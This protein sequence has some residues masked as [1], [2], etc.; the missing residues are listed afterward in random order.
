MKT[1]IV[2]VSTGMVGCQ[3]QDSFE[4]EDDTTEEEVEDM[5]REVMFN[6]INWT[7]YT[8]EEK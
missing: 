1:I 4:V 8:K 5:A 6:M 2:K 3:R 7:Y